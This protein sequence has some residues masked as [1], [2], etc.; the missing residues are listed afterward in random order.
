MS[1]IGRDSCKKLAFFASLLMPCAC[2]ASAG[3]EAAGPSGSLSAG[4]SGA[5]FATGGAWS[6]SS[7]GT[8][9]GGA[10]GAPTGGAA[11]SASGGFGASGLGGSAGSGSGGAPTG[12]G[13]SGATGANGGF[14]G[15]G[16]TAPAPIE[17]MIGAGRNPDVAVDAS[18]KIHVVYIEAQ[19]KLMYVLASAN[20][21]AILQKLQIGTVASYA[22]ADPHVRVDASGRPHV[23]YVDKNAD[24]AKYTRQSG[25]SWT[26]PAAI[27]QL[28]NCGACPGIRKPRLS[29]APGADW[30]T[31]Y[32]EDRRPYARNVSAAGVIDPATNQLGILIASS[33]SA[34]EDTGGVAVCA[35]GTIHFTVRSATPNRLYYRYATTA[36]LSA[37]EEVT[38]AAGASDFSDVACDA[39]DGS[40]A[41]IAAVQSSNNGNNIHY[42]VR[43][44]SGYT[45]REFGSS[46]INLQNH[47]G[48]GPSIAVDPS[49][50][51]YITWSG[52]PDPS[53]A[54]HAY[55]RAWIAAVDANDN[56]I[57]VI[58]LASVS[59]RQ[60][61]KFSYPAVAA[62]PCG[63]A[64]A[65][66]EDD[67]N[68]GS[69][70]VYASNFNVPQ[71]FCVN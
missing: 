70:A 51:S 32:Y 21:P 15:S 57:G 43:R 52:G 39:A 19:T 12:G 65:V 26:A 61:D 30:A 35:N 36:G 14:G 56:V 22:V 7:G 25:S 13:G 33:A 11:G 16:A 5:H 9:A 50:T 28:I 3:D 68:G 18:G 64:W 27:P 6:G 17:F 59:S 40:V 67:R 24:A 10:S 41:K 53:G 71:G 45:M 62:A 2:A 47:D 38:P 44:A 23:L 60:G 1:S 34:E 8:S 55:D 58:P 42:I 49:D 46:T 54:T 69:Y 4:G 20:P 31:L 48:V 37:I 66:W 29:I 63:G